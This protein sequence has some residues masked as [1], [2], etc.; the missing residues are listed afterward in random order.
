MISVPVSQTDS[1]RFAVIRNFEPTRIERELLAQ[2]FEV[3]SHGPGHP[4]G[5]IDQIAAST[6]SSRSQV[7]TDARVERGLLSIDVSQRD[8]RES[9]A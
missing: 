1:K 5:D 8:S 3:I 2:V 7:A 9:A 4:D 6:I